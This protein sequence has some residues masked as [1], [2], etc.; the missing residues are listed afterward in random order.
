LTSLNDRLIPGSISCNNFF[1]PLRIKK[2]NINCLNNKFHIGSIWK[3]KFD[4]IEINKKHGKNHMNSFFYFVTW[5]PDNLKNTC[6]L[7]CRSMECDRLTQT[8]ASKSEG[9]LK[10]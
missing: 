2:K 1:P 7:C 6:G 3:L 4:Y 8:I 5:L 9:S 10:I